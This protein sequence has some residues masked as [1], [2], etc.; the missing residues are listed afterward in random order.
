M[1]NSKP[2]KRQR[3]LEFAVHVAVQATGTVIGGLI[4]AWLGQQ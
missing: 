1:H 4:L 3:L 2:S